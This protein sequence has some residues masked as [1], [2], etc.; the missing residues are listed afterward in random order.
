MSAGN[1]NMSGRMHAS[2]SLN[3]RQPQS[4]GASQTKIKAGAKKINQS[5]SMNPS[6]RE[7]HNKVQAFLDETSQ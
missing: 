7:T 5:S 1:I 6:E 2:N 4:I 3:A